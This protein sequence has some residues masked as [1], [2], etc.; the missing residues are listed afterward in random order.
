MSPS[1]LVSSVVSRSSKALTSFTTGLLNVPSFGS[2]FAETDRD[3]MWEAVV[4]EIRRLCLSVIEA[5]KQI[6]Y[7]NQ[8]EPEKVKQ[9]ETFPTV[10]NKQVL[11]LCSIKGMQ[12]LCLL[13]S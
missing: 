12:M 11:T 8:L 10:S 3:D 13:S 4:I 6:P 7:I 2:R 9:Q 5:S 1:C